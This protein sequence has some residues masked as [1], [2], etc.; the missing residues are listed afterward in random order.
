MHNSVG[1]TDGTAKHCVV[2]PGH[3]RRLQLRSSPNAANIIRQTNPA[4]MRERRSRRHPMPAQATAQ[5]DQ[6]SSLSPPERFSFSRSGSK[7]GSCVAKLE[8]EPM[9]KSTPMLAWATTMVQGLEEVLDSVD[10]VEMSTDELLEAINQLEDALVEAQGRAKDYVGGLDVQALGVS[11]LLVVVQL[12]FSSW[13][14]IGKAALTDEVDPLSF[15]LVREI[16]ASILLWGAANKFEGSFK[17]LQPGDAR[18][19]LTL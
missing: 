4:V 12:T 9:D 6:K 5:P 15:A 3:H 10:G 7:E 16:F 2:R 19:F 13:Y 8:Y 14:A 17:L 18:K 1:M 11:A